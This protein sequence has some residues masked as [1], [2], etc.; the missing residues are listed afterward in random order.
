[1]QWTLTSPGGLATLVVTLDREGR[2][3]YEVRRRE[4]AMITASRLGVE[5]LDTSFAGGLALVRPPG[6]PVV[7]DTHYVVGHGKRGSLHDHATSMTIP[8][9]NGDGARL[10]LDLRAYDDAAAFRYRFPDDAGRR[11]VTG[12]LTTFTLAGHGRAWLQPTQPADGYGP[13]HEN[14]YLDGVPIGSPSPTRSWELPGTFRTEHGWVLITEA[15]LDRTFHGTRLSGTPTGLGYEVVGPDPGEGFGVGAPTASATGPWT[16]PWRV[17]ALADTAAQLLETTAVTHL[18]EPS[19]LGDLSW[20]RP[21]RVSWS[22]WSDNSSPGHLDT[23]RA[24]VDFAAEMGWEYSLVDAGW[25][26]HT[27]QQLRDL[28]AYAGERDVGILLW[29]N[30]GGPHNAVPGTPRDLMH[31]PRERRRELARIAAWGVAGIKVDF[32]HSDKQDGIDRYLGILEDA[33]QERLLVNF[34]G[35][36]IPRGW[37]RTWP[38]L[39][40]LESVRGAEMYLFDADYARDAVTHNTILPFTRNVIGPMD[41]TPVA[42]TDKLSPRRTTATHELALAT[43]YESGLL[44]Y[45]DSPESYRTLHPAVL[46]VLRSTPAA[47]DET[48]G[49]AGSPGDHVVLARRSGDA[50]HLAGIAGPSPVDAFD[51]D[52]SRLEPPPRTWRVVHD[53]DARDEVAVQEISL[54]TDRAG[55]VLRVPGMPA[56]GGFVATAVDG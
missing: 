56:G 51:L 33:A 35:C 18:A 55:E 52:I 15:G 19:R 29:Y 37:E 53:G 43:V 50:W 9:R 49:L 6:D 16:L 26:V 14:L 45:A 27:E 12:E 46:Q 36:T 5:R 17:V 48:V 39:M 24:Y 25:D 23:L 31:T 22:W 40:T 7:V 44:H 42:F 38:N 3:W 8:L 2:L 1:M 54:R 10:D 30:S 13:S 28:V 32:F 4:I 21:G 47:W 41:Y 20:I 11:T 34:H